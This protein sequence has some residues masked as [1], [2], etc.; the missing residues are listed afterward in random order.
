MNHGIVRV[1][2]SKRKRIHLV[3]GTKHKRGHGVHLG[4]SSGTLDANAGTIA[5]TLKAGKYGRLNRIRCIVWR[6]SQEIPDEARA[7]VNRILNQPN[8]ISPRVK[9]VLVEYGHRHPRRG[10]NRNRIDGVNSPTETDIH[11]R[12]SKRPKAREWRAGRHR[13]Q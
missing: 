11:E 1:V 6:S 13:S 7:I 12:R 4:I 2:I 9:A 5:D 8:A 10:I 3:P